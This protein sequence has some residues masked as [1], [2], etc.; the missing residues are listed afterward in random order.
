[1]ISKE[2]AEFADRMARTVVT[3]DGLTEGDAR[4]VRVWDLCRRYQEFVEWKVMQPLEGL[5]IPVLYAMVDMGHS[6]AILCRDVLPH[7][8]DP[9]GTVPRYHP[10]C[11]LWGVLYNAHLLKIGSLLNQDISQFMIPDEEFVDPRR[12]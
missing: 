11:S 9:D 12:N 4:L 1:M 3:R 6:I 7:M 8:A 10:L 2:A 5:P